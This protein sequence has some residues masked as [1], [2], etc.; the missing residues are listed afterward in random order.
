MMFSFFTPIEK[1]LQLEA[2]HGVGDGLVPSIIP[3]LC[4]AIRRG[5][6]FAQ[7]VCLLCFSWTDKRHK[8]RQTYRQTDTGKETD[9]RTDRQTQTDRQTDRQKNLLQLEAL[10]GLGDGL[11]PSIIPR[12][13]TGG[14]APGVFFVIRDMHTVLGGW[15]FFFRLAGFLLCVS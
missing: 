3:A 10:H 2:L 7:Q 14:C 8:D 15:I 13:A 1:L 12:S 9:I 4:D 5:G 11:A 6:G